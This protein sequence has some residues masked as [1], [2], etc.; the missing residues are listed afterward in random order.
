MCDYSMHALKNRKA[1]VGDKIKT[2]DFSRHSSPGIESCKPGEAMVA[3]CLLPGTGIEFDQPVSYRDNGYQMMVSDF[4]IGRYVH[5]PIHASYSDWLQFPDGTKT[6][7]AYLIPG[8]TGTVTYVPEEAIKQVDE[9]APAKKK[10]AMSESL[11]RRI[12]DLMGA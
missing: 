2:S 5:R 6:L 11:R 10:V 1:V 4:K 8:Q 3:I 9:P 7:I 12:S